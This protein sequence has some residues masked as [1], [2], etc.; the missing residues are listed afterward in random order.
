MVLHNEGFAV[1]TPL[2]LRKREGNMGKKSHPVLSDYLIISD[3]TKME[4]QIKK[5]DSFLK[6][7]ERNVDEWSLEELIEGAMAKERHPFRIGGWIY[8]ELEEKKGLDEVR[9]AFYMDADEFV[10]E[11]DH[12]LDRLR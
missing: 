11:Y 12:L 8:K 4:K 7:F 9:E 10:E 5:Y 2:R 1:Y 6:E 3:E